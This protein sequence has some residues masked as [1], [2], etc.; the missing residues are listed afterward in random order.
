VNVPL[1]VT[2]PVVV[3]ALLATREDLRTRKIPNL[4]TAPAFLLGLA[5]HLAMGGPRGLL[6]A[7]AA[8]LLA[9]AILLPGWLLKFMGAGDVKLMAAIG[10]WIGS[11]RLALYAALFSLVAGGIISLVAAARL[12]ILS[13]TVRNAALLL[14]RVVA[15]AGLSGA[16]VETSG[17][18]VPKALAFLAG[19]LFALWWRT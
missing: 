13:R 18:R 2:V 8:G 17:V 6:A 4:L 9:G 15:G 10:A 5:A 11:P 3:L 7:L 19:S 1:W 16:P 14:P 12:G